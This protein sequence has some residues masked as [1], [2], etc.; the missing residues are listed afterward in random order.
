[1]KDKSNHQ[2]EQQELRF[3]DGE[4]TEPKP[5]KPEHRLN[6]VPAPTFGET[7]NNRSPSSN[8]IHYNRRRKNKPGADK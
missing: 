2:H 4:E 5:E 8:E 6:G 1:M 7:V 3:R